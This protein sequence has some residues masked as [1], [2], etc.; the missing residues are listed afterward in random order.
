MA[1]IYITEPGNTGG[2]GAMG[3]R[4]LSQIMRRKGHE[5]VDVR[6][7]K[8]V[9]GGEQRGLFAGLLDEQTS[10]T[11][12]LPKP[13][14]WFI[15]TLYPRQ[16]VD[17]PD[18]FRRIGLAPMAQDRTETDPLVCFGGQAMISP[19]PVLAFADVIALGDGEATGVAIGG[20]LDSGKSKMQIL[21]L[22]RGKP[23]FFVPGGGERLRRLELPFH[24]TVVSTDD[25]KSKDVPVIEAARGCASKCSFCPIG[26]AG[27]TYREAP[28]SAVES[29]L[30]QLRGKRVNVFA[31]DYSSISFS[32]DIDSL[33]E[34][35]GCKQTG[36]DA[37]LD[38][39]ARS[40]AIG[41][42][43]KQYSFG[44]EGASERIRKAIGKP[45]TID[46]ILATMKMLKD[47]H[48]II[49]YVILGFPG[50][51]SKDIDEFIKLCEMT[52]GE[53]RGKLDITF[54]H[55]QSVPHTPLQWID[56]HYRQDALAAHGQL[57]DIFRG[58]WTDEGV[59][60]LGSQFK[61]IELHEHDSFLQRAPMG[62]AE[63]LLKLN[64]S[65]PKMADGR[66]RDVAA[67]SSLDVEEILSP[68]RL[69]ESL[70]WDFVDVGVEKRMVQKGWGNYAKQ[71]QI[72]ETGLFSMA[73][74]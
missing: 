61:G 43:V 31:P 30:V 71:M 7:F 12:H 33:I 35:N 50:E 18:M 15:S 38:A 68:L 60:I 52:K 23:G 17:L 28:K 74:E 26:W 63:Y 41:G 73:A 54:T 21:E 57:R 42:A 34:S 70:N 55:L 24:G 2:V 37:R 14:A 5:V 53:Y 56:A 3:K 27:G 58:W 45:L 22:L 40:M 11:G 65:K 20:L 51:T 25:L 67:E 16:W 59:K 39:A 6:L 10:D 1:K 49:W 36:R 29:A 69:D 32:E 72:M 13:D 47:V 64:G 48:H 9:E 4:I 19:A 44:I 46:K 8:T 62:A 66:W